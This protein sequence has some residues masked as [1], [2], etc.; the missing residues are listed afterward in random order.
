MLALAYLA[1][2]MV[3]YLAAALQL[4]VQPPS[5]VMALGVWGYNGTQ[6]AAGGWLLLQLLASTAVAGGCARCLC[7]SELV[8]HALFA[9]AFRALGMQQRLLRVPASLLLAARPCRPG[10][11]SPTPA[12]LAVSA[13][14][15][16][17]RHRSRVALVTPP[18]ARELRQLFS[19]R[20]RRT[21]GRVQLNRQVQT[22]TGPWGGWRQVE[23]SS[24]TLGLAHPRQMTSCGPCTGARWD[25]FR[26]W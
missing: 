8:T 24:G 15:S 17:S 18:P 22:A 26:G 9:W 12:T 16:R 25:T 4:V 5:W 23:Y 6:A 19:V 11:A 21:Q 14:L 3:N 7:A 13:G 1:W 2:L 20:D 10:S